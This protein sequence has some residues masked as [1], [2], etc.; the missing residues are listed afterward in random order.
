MRTRLLAVPVLSLIA[1]SPEGLAGLQPPGTGVREVSHSVAV[2][3][4]SSATVLTVSRQLHNDTFEYQA[5]NR[6][7]PLPDGAI[8]TSLRVGTDGHWQRAP[9]LASNEETAVRWNE[10]TSPGEATPATLGLLEWAW[11]GGVDLNLFGEAPGA[12]VDVEY[13]VEL[14]P[15]YESGALTFD[16]PLEDQSDV[17][18]APPQFHLAEAPAA[19][20]ENV[21]DESP[22]RA[23]TGFRVS[24]PRTPR[25]Y[26]DARWATWAVGPERTMWR[27]EV[28]AAPQLEPAPVRPNVVFAIDASW[29]EDAEGIASQLELIGPYLASSPDALV[30]IVVYRRFAER[31]F[32]RFVPAADVARMLAA[33]PKERLAPG[34]GSHLERGAG[35][36]AEALSQ[37]PGTGRVVL[38]TDEVLR[39]G[40]TNELALSALAPAPADA[41]VHLVAR[42]SSSGH[43]LWELRN[44][45]APLSPIAAAH[46]GVFFRISGH[47][48]DPAQAARTLLGLVRPIRIDNFQ[49]EAKGLVDD[50]VDVDSTLQEGATIRRSAIGARPPSEVTLTGKIWARDFHRVVRVDAPLCARLPGLAV[51]D[52]ELRS[53]LSDEELLRAAFTAHAVSPVTSYLSAPPEA[54]ASTAGVLRGLE[55][56]LGLRGIG[57]GGCGGSSTCGFGHAGRAVDLQAAL[58][59][60]L[61]PGIAACE[62]RLGDVPM[63]TFSIEATGDEV[64]EV[65]VKASS[66]ALGD[67]LTEAAWAIRLTPEFSWHRTYEVTSR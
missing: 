26:A 59:A 51:G 54:S 1:C 43:E 22:D 66:A 36:A 15:R 30:E 34:N 45:D 6:H 39:E 48:G 13:Q 49:V 4:D 64:V 24:Q 31:L 2:R 7:L 17:W 63:A 19:T 21:L 12:T 37:V 50:V 62:Q 61:A 38:F 40:F 65:Q 16:Y 46:G 35:L 14:S 58:R 53:Q 25:E 28:D 41:V 3:F 23:P 47:P 8:A 11:G 29:S 33:V 55:G 9:E 32:G 42:S 67:C 5:L 44:D 52:E 56:G 60:L 57:C 10:L 18:F 27:L 20:I